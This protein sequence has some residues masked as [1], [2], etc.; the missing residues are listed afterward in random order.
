[1]KHTIK[2]YLYF[3]YSLCWFVYYTIKSYL[4]MFG[5]LC[6]FAYLKLIGKD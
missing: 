6:K 2:D 1:M 3:I 5:Y 4:L